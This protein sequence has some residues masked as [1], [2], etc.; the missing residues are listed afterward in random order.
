MVSSIGYLAGCQ[1]LTVVSISDEV[2]RMNDVQVDS[3]R[4]KP[5]EASHQLLCIITKFNRKRD[6]LHPISAHYSSSNPM[7]K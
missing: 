5:N 7:V 6:S 4:Q 3:G 1:L 2:R